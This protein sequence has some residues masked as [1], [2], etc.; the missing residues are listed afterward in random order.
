MSD[1]SILFNTDGRLATEKGKF[2]IL[3]DDKNIFPAS[4]FVWVTSPEVVEEAGPDYEKT[5]VEA[6]KGLTLTT[7]RKLNAEMERGKAPAEVAAGYLESIG[8]SG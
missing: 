5:I 6:Q 8:Y 4:N 1:A 3:E 7:M 2:V